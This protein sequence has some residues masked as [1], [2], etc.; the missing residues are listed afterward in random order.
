MQNHTAETHIFLT[1]ITLPQDTN[2]FTQHFLTTL[3]RICH[4][5]STEDTSARE[6]NVL[7]KEPSQEIWLQPLSLHN[8]DRIRWET[9]RG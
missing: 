2:V 8:Q 9:P 6:R 3:P 7:F 1:L 4:P 5:S